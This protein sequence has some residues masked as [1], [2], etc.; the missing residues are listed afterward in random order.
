MRRDVD[1]RRLVQ[2]TGAAVTTTEKCP[3][4]ARRFAAAV[5]ALSEDDELIAVGH[6]AV[7]DALTEWAEDGTSLVVASLVR[8]NPTKTVEAALRIALKTMADKLDDHAEACS[9]DDD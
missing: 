3:E 4:C 8:L 1:P 6:R 2:R 7:M 5:R 9:G